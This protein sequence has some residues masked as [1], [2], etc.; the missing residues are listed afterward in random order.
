VAILITDKK[1]ITQYD[2]SRLLWL[3]FPIKS[4]AIWEVARTD[5]EYI[6]HET[7][8]QIQTQAETNETNLPE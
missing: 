4:K 6:D 3:L 8:N 1:W 7:K 2:F 5:N